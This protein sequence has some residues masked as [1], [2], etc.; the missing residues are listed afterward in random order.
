[1]R[2]KHFELERIFMNI[3]VTLALANILFYIGNF[4]EILA[5]ELFGFTTSEE[6]DTLLIAESFISLM[7]GIPIVF[8][9][10]VMFYFY[11]Y[12]TYNWAFK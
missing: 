2:D 12:F 7:I 9:V 6:I 4:I 10:M 3:A 8:T 1:M 5:P 11:L